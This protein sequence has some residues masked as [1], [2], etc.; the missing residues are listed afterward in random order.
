M[1]SLV[2]E[3]QLDSKRPGYAFREP[4]N[5]YSDALLKA[6]WR[7]AMPRG[8]GWGTDIYRG[9]RATKCFPLGGG[10]VALSKMVVTDQA[11][12]Q[13]RRGIRRVEIDVLRE[14]DVIPALRARLEA[15]PES[16]RTAAQSRLNVP[17][18]MEI[19]DRALPKLSGSESQVILAH[20]YSGPEA[21]QM[22][23]VMVLELAT[24]WLLRA[25]PGWG[26]LFSFTTLALTHDGESRLLA[27][28]LDRVRQMH[29]APAI[30]IR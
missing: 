19:I 13:G 23:E 6:V 25:V 28:P 21:W 17:R 18:W 2:I 20:P 4:T 26:R 10:L 8:Q 22:I 29:D 27:V 9:A 11:D 5:G 14:P 15:Y 12:E 16:I 30:L 7:Q 3:Y 1:S 24:A